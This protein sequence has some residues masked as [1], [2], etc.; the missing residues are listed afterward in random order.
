MPVDI[1]CAVRVAHCGGRMHE[2]RGIDSAQD[3]VRLEH[4]V[5]L[6]AVTSFHRAVLAGDVSVDVAHGTCSG[7]VAPDNIVDKPV[8]ARGPETC[9]GRGG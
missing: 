3:A 7:A 1:Q 5:A 2:M 8:H 6:S 9:A 4:Y